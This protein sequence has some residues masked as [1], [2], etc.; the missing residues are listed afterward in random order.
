[1]SARKN[2]F[3]VLVGT[4]GSG[5][6]EV[7]ERLKKMFPGNSCVFPCDS[8]GGGA[9]DASHVRFTTRVT[10][11]ARD[12]CH[13]EI[14][15]DA[16]LSFFWARLSTLIHGEVLE[17]YRQG[18]LIIMNGFGGTILSH[19][20][21]V[22]DDNQIDDLVALHKAHISACVLARDLEPPL[23][24]HLRASSDVSCERLSRQGRV[25]DLDEFRRYANR[26]NEMIDFYGNLPGQT[27]VP[28]DANQSIEC[29]IDDVC[30]V[31][32]AYYPQYENLLDKEILST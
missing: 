8:N 30:A 13:K 23:Y 31:I 21:S 32:G 29:V 6:T 24:I 12:G 16:Q 19:A 4:H 5:K 2:N 20:L 26:V 7:H 1:M 3:F 9:S 18:K 15:P 28:V 11:I 14:P 25:D 17:W 27:V 10:Q 22:A